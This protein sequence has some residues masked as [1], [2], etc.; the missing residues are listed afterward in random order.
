M[1]Y[2]DIYTEPVLGD[3][4]AYEILVGV[5]YKT[6]CLLVHPAVNCAS[7][8]QCNHLWETIYQEMKFYLFFSS[9]YIPTRWWLRRTLRA[10]KRIEYRARLVV[11]F[12][13][14]FRYDEWGDA[15]PQEW[16]TLHKKIVYSN[17]RRHLFVLKLPN[18]NGQK[19][20][21]KECGRPV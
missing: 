8:Q 16:F 14:S 20:R 21:K 4:V 1:V 7:W 6:D 2:V 3:V 5:K 17:A 18:S 11:F 9:T 13:I 15:F 12:V 10:L 19:R